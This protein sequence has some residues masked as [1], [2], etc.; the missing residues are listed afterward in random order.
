MPI[1]WYVLGGVLL[2]VLANGLI[3]SFTGS[4]EVN[5]VAKIEAIGHDPLT[6]A[7]FFTLH[8]GEKIYYPANTPAGTVVA[9][10][11]V[12]F[13][14]Y[15]PFWQPDC[16]VLIIQHEEEPALPEWA[17]TEPTPPALTYP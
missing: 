2:M 4:V 11:Y 8:G 3:G 15:C 7:K 5:R 17:Q 6:G 12:G 16:P 9:G 1:W 10:Q 14:K 13:W